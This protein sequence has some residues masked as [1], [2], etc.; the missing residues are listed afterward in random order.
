M[1]INQQLIA[2]CLAKDRKAQYQLYKSCFPV[3]MS[4]CMRYHK[5]EEDARAALNI[6]YM[7]IL[8]NLQKYNEKV[9]FIA[10][11][12]RIMINAIID[13]FRKNRKVKE[14]IEYRDFSAHDHSYDLID[15]NTADQI[16]DAAQLES[17]IRLL[18]PMSQKVFNL[19]AIDGY[20]HKEIGK[21]L[22][23]SDG[24]SKWH[25]SSA[26]KKLQEMIHKAINTT[27]VS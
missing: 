11:I 20:S 17:F 7:K 2:D 23:I 10:W 27:K 24:T 4:I 13:D 15:F 5:N 19:Y 6:G 9:P 21:M 1:K 12:R 8:T 22:S 26:R 18:P 3:L 25:L 16:F 14:L